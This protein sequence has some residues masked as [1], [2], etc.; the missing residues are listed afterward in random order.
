MG[1]KPREFS[2]FLDLGDPNEGLPIV[3]AVKRGLGRLSGRFGG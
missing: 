1:T 3:S 2:V